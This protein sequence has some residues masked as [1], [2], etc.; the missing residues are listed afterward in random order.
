[1]R[2]EKDLRYV[3]YVVACRFVDLV[4]KIVLKIDILVSRDLSSLSQEN[5]QF[6][7]ICTTNFS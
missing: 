1:M 7:D 3:C 4:R 5:R 2:K 6:V